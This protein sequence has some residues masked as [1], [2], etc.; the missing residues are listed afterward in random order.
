MP[1]VGYPVNSRK[2]FVRAPA[3]FASR[4]ATFATPARAQTSS[5]SP[6]ALR[7]ELD[8]G[9]EAFRAGILQAILYFSEIMVSISVRANLDRE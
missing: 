3:Q 4:S 6:P 7:R 8:Q 9:I 5:L 1:P 2:E